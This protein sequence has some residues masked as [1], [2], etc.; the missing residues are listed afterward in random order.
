MLLFF[1]FFESSVADHSLLMSLKPLK[2]SR[3][4]SIV[5]ELRSGV[6]WWGNYHRKV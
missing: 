5:S 1:F 6:W 2:L 4:V 3:Q